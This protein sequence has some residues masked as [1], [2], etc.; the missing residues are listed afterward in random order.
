MNQGSRPIGTSIS[1][2]THPKFCTPSTT[3]LNSLCA[4]SSCISTLT[5]LESEYR[6]TS[7]GP[8]KS[9]SCEGEPA[10]LCRTYY[11]SSTLTFKRFLTPLFNQGLMW[12]GTA[13]SLCLVTFR[14][15]VRLRYFKRVYADDIFILVAW[16]ILLASS[17]ILQTQ[18]G[19][20]YSSF[21]LSAGQ[22]QPTADIL[23]A[24]QSLM[25]ATLEVLILFLSCLWSVKVSI[26]LFFYRLGHRVRSLKIWWW[27]VMGFTVLT[28]AICIGI[29]PYWCL[30]GSADYILS[31]LTKP[32][33]DRYNDSVKLNVEHRISKALRKTLFITTLPQ[34]FSLTL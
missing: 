13:L 18:Q 34:T 9:Y 20:M 12:A 11:P 26:L 24:E 17:I 31:E 5:C 4:F 7:H 21:K 19:N 14:V 15:F 8:G 32:L 28:W 10:G 6:G 3:S 22:I 2:R 29:L 33:W 30:L 23:A 27:S 1:C 25:H 16:I